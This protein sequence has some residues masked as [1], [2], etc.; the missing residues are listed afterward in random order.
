MKAIQLTALGAPDVLKLIDVP[1]PKPAADEVVV[2]VAAAGVNYKDVS[3][4]RGWSITPLQPPYIPGVEAAGVVES[5][6]ASVKDVTVGERVAYVAL[7]VGSYA[8]FAAVK[9]DRLIPVPDD[10]SLEDA[11]ALT[12]QGLTAHYLLYE[13]ALVGPGKS[14]LVHAAA[15]GMGRL[16][17]QWAKHLGARVIGTTSSSAKAAVAREAGADDVILYNDQDFVA[18]TLRLTAERGADVV[19]DGVG[20]STL[21]GSLEA[22]ATRGCIVLYGSASGPSEP[23]APNELQKRSRTIAGGDLFDF[24]V[25][26]EEMLSRS[27]QMFAGVRAGWLRQ[28]ITRFPLEA[29]AQAH[30][31]LEDRANTGKV[32][33]TVNV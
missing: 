16:L 3:M 24:I 22:V 6:G 30:Q 15:G 17:C 18:E 5:V 31:L 1:V 2:K 8:E 28:S 7:S 10:V 19:F 27:R 4:R 33:L 12:V 29:A 23:I 21:P 9:A 20:K 11:A 25:Q 14:V 32:I 13:Y 26:R